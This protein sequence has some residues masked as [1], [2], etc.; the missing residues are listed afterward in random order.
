[1]FD[2]C[3]PMG[4]SPPGSSDHGISQAGILEW[5]AISF[6]RGSPKFR[7]QTRVSCIAGRF[8]TNRATS[9]APQYFLANGLSCSI[10]CGSSLTGDQTRVSCTGYADPS[11]TGHEGS[12]I[13]VYF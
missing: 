8:F 10:A 2:P 7:D 5:V 3:N 11:P 4:Y 13:G 6:C 1:M 12:P 9:E